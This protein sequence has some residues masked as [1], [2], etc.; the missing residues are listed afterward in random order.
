M[1]TNPLVADTDGDG[2]SDGVEDFNHDGVRQSYETNA[3]QADSEGDGCND[4]AEDLNGNHVVDSGE[5][6]PLDSHDCG[7]AR[8]NRDSDCDGLT[9]EVE[10]NI[11]HTLP[12]NPDTDGD[13]IRDGRERGVTTNPDP[14]SCPQ[15]AFTSNVL[16]VDPGTVTDPTRVDT[17]CDGLRDGVEDADRDG[18][19]DAAETDPSDPDTDGDAL[20]DGLESGV[21]TN[22]DPANCPGFQ[23][24][25]NPATTTDP[26]NPDSD[27]D[28]VWDG[29]EDSNQNGAVES[30]E[31]ELDPGNAGDVTAPDFQACAQ[32][33]SPGTFQLK[34]IQIIPVPGRNADVTFAVSPDFDAANTTTLSL[35]GENRGVM[36]F[37]PTLQVAAF[38]FKITPGLDG[39]DVS[40]QLQTLEGLMAGAG[41]L[42]SKFV[43]V[44]DTWDPPLPATA[45]RAA[46]AQYTWTDNG[47]DTVGKAAND[48]VEAMLP[49]V[50]SLLPGA[51]FG[52]ETGEFR[53]K[54]ELIRRSANPNVVVGALT[55]DTD[56]SPITEAR[57]FRLDDITNGSA[58]AQYGD[59]TGVQC[60][61]MTVQPYSPIDF[62]WVVD[63]SGSM[64][65][66]QDAVATAA[67]QMASQLGNTTVA[68]RIAVITT[69]LDNIS[70]RLTGGACDQDGN[71]PGYSWGTCAY[72]SSRPRYCSFTSQAST[73][74]SCIAA[75]RTG[76]S[77]SERP[78]RSLACALK[79]GGNPPT[80]PPSPYSNN[81]GRS[82]GYNYRVPP[83]TYAM[84]DRSA[85][86]AQKLRDSALP[87]FIFLTDTNEQSDG[88]YVASSSDPVPSDSLTKISDWAAFFKNFDGEGT[89][90]S[91]AF[92]AGLVCPPGTN[93]SDYDLEDYPNYMNTRWPTFFAEMGGV[94]ADLPD[95]DDLQQTAKIQAAVALIL[96]K[97]VGRVSP[98][99]LAKAPISATIK[100]ATAALLEGACNANDIPRSRTNGWD[101]DGAHRT[102][103]FYGAC[104]PKTTELGKRI[105]VSYRYWIDRT[106]DPD[107]GS[108]PCGGPCPAGQVCDPVT[109]TCLCQGNCGGTCSAPLACDMSSCGC[110]CPPDCRGCQ[111]GFTCNAS[112]SVCACSCQPDPACVLRPGHVFDSNT[113]QCV[114]SAA[115]LGCGPNETAD[116]ATCS[117]LCKP[118]CGGC[119]APRS[120]CDP[121]A[122]ACSCDPVQTCGVGF[123]MD[124]ATC[125]CVCDPGSLF[126]LPSEQPNAAACTC[127]CRSDCGGCVPGYACDR[128]SCSCACDAGAL[129][130]QAPLAPDPLSCSCQCPSDCGG[131]ANG[132]VCNPASCACECP[133][134]VTCGPGERLDT[135]TCRCI[136][137]PNS[138]F[139]GPNQQPNSATCSCDCRS[140]CGGCLPGYECDTPTCSCACDLDSTCADPKQKLDPASCTCVCDT[141]QLGCQAP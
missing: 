102:L 140:D 90:M 117:C 16:D 119:A 115:A 39:A 131:C 69:D 13:G 124:P 62:V 32:G 137:D 112:P 47:D 67:A 78:F 66:E 14:L 81:C 84:L 37:D 8:T 122:C 17:D 110:V 7:P 72:P 135:A 56:A 68:W 79:A 12:N 19:V 138:L 73:F 141:A 29:T 97:A 103:K 44:F 10:T 24:D 104:R 48:L 31:G 101:Y 50:G 92:V 107:G 45:F 15:A 98:Y 58:V 111:P 20:N 89:D 120:S 23:A 22:P 83:G 94:Y 134:T 53:L 96:D 64:S 85:A 105:S 42:G 100:V 71:T 60:D 125:T 51:A 127:E 74:Q 70:N 38:A 109:N 91:S 75:L 35:S 28:Q 128:P 27:G 123:R 132:F 116:L 126:C 49:G 133:S 40:A 65:N 11:T 87:A 61:R 77:G 52:S 18:Q 21:T 6:N 108:P 9:D 5:S 36:L 2:L 114:C 55:R 113:C 82:S 95:D 99:K 34:P 93:C 129:A 33:T 1:G 80:N 30:S 4:G 139:C 59:T 57:S 121:V 43:Q 118:D 26:R 63:N 41:T 76:G 54:L 88:S 130:C 46:Q 25:A 3:T 136:C 106:P 86:D